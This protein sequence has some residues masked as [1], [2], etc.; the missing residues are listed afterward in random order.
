MHSKLLFYSIALLGLVIFDSTQQKY[1]L[2]TFNLAT[3][4]ISLAELFFFHLSRWMCWLLIVLPIS[5]VYRRTLIRTNS[6]NPKLTWIHL[7]TCI[8]VALLGVIVISTISTFEVHGHIEWPSLSASLLFYFFQKGLTFTVATVIVVLIIH[9]QIS[10]KLIHE[11]SAQIHIYQ[12]RIDEI[13]QF[14]G[15]AGQLQIKIGHKL[16]TVPI[17]EI[18]WI[19]S[20]D[21]CVKVHVKTRSYTIRKSLKALE[22]QL[23]D[24]GFMRIHRCAL[25]NLRHVNLINTSSQ[26]VGLIDQ[27]EVPASKS[28]IRALKNQ[29][30]A[31]S[32]AE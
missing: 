18:I 29:L 26:K 1:Y 11:Q 21:Y 19:Q 25:I 30:T 17:E 24:F 3:R 23:S 2:D 14:N 28:G 4:E 32:I 31:Q 9:D 20:D 6:L 7:A 12:K 16:T 10:K 15:S 5:L 8:G 22:Q 27:I 13:Q